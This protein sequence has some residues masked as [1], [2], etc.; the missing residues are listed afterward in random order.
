MVSETPLISLTSDVSSSLSPILIL[1][2]FPFPLKID[3]M[4]VG[5]LNRGTKG[6][7]AGLKLWGLMYSKQ[8]ASVRQH[9]GSDVGS[10]TVL[11]RLMYHVQYILYSDTLKL[12]QITQ[13][14]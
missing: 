11:K 4:G 7:S 6:L 3:H 13:Y 2:Y 14:H 10:S 5:D 9:A 1:L 8:Y 12:I